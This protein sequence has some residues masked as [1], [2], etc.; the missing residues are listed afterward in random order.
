[1]LIKPLKVTIVIPTYNGANRIVNTL[2]ALNDQSYTDFEVI[3]AI[4]GS[5]D[6]TKEKLKNFKCKLVRQPNKGRASIRNFGAKHSNGEILIF[7]DDDM[8]PDKECVEIHLKH[9]LSHPMSI[10][11]GSQIEDFSKIK[12]DIQRF[13]ANT[14]RY[15]EKHI[16]LNSRPLNQKDL[17]LTAANFSLPKK[18]FA[19]LGGFDDRLRDIEDLDL[20]IRAYKKDVPIYFNNKALGWHDDFITC[21]DYI[22][23]RREYRKALTD[24]INLKPEHESFLSKKKLYPNSFKK[25]IF[26]FFSHAYWVKMIDR[27]KLIFI[28]EKLRFKIYELVIWGLS[29]YFPHRKI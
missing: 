26:N 18:I 14:S 11:T 10:L 29:E 7:F 13:K 22:S 1:M 2:E 21:K 28:P 17:H 4:D 27:N 25:L 12:T 8:R 23:R 16:P 20:A 19:S 9:H 15:W 24:L 6:D 5:T 3:V